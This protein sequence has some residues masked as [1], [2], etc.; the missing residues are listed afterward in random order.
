VASGFILYIHPQLQL[1]PNEESAGLLRVLLYTTD[2]SAFAGDVPEVPEWTGPPRT[3]ATT[4]ILLYLSFLA[5]MTAVMYAIFAKQLLDLYTSF[6]LKGNTRDDPHWSTKLKIFGAVLRI[7]VFI[8]SSLMQG[9]LFFLTLAITVYIWDINRTVGLLILGFTACGV[10]FYILLALVSLVNFNFLDFSF[11]QNP[12][13]RVISRYA[14]PALSHA[15]H[16]RVQNLT[17]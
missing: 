17:P 12:W 3:V 11:L 9:A 15:D 7:F 2:S 13:D 16:D 14:S 5:S 4:M 10:P 6:K 8:L 1:D